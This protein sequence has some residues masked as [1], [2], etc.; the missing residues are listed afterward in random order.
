MPLLE[1]LNDLPKQLIQEPPDNLLLLDRQFPYLCLQVFDVL[2]VLSPVY[3]LLLQ[4]IFVAG[5]SGFGVLVDVVDVGDYLLL[6]DG[7]HVVVDVEVELVH[8]L[9]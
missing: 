1:I 9:L 8:L 2:L 3:F 5:D 4:K 6:F 7:V